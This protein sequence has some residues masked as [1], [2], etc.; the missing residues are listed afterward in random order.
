M[1]DH[2]SCVS[3][4]VQLTCLPCFSPVGVLLELR[5]VGPKSPPLP[6][7]PSLAPGKLLEGIWNCRR[8]LLADTLL[9]TQPAVGSELD[10][11][12]RLQAV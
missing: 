2:L 5:G 9:P 4:L 1:S 12:K 7:K 8:L 10:W 3:L 6:S 11:P